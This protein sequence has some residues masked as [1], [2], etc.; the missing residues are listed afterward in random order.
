MRARESAEEQLNELWAQTVS[1]GNDC[2]FELSQ[3]DASAA[4]GV[5]PIKKAT[6]SSEKTP[7]TTELV[8]VDGAT[9]ISVKHAD[10]HFDRVRVKRCVV[11]IDQSTL[12]LSFAQL[13]TAILVDL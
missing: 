11:A 9:A 5:K 3:R 13:T 8:E 6:P 7:E 1:K 4:I 12:Q 10:H 2:V